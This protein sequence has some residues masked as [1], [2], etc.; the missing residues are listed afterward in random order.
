MTIMQRTCIEILAACLIAAAVYFILFRIGHAFADE[1][2]QETARP[3]LVAQLDAAPAVAPATAAPTAPD[4]APDNASAALPPPVTGE[5]TDVGG[6]I[7]TGTRGVQDIRGGGLLAG[8]AALLLVLVYG[9]RWLFAA[10]RVSV[11]EGHPIRR[12]AL[13]ALVALA[14]QAALVLMHAD[15]WRWGMLWTIVLAAAA[16]GKLWDH[17]PLPTPPAKAKD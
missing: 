1:R 6:A 5:P 12:Y 8:L 7:S 13:V 4:A 15:V 2:G 3:V 14:Q 9:L 16:A 17:L 11:F 10:V